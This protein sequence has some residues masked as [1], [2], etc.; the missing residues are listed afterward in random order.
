MA[1]KKT[2]NTVKA[3]PA[4]PASSQEREKALETAMAQIEKQYGK[5]AIMRLGENASMSVEHIRTGSLALD[6]AL[7]I[8]GIPRGRIVEIYGPES[9]GKTTVAL[10]CV[11]EAQKA[12]GNAAFIDVE[13]ALDPVY[14]AN[15]GVDIDNLL[16]SQPDSGEQALEIAEA[17]VRS[18]AIDIIVV[19][20]VAALTTKAEIEGE[21]GDAHVGQLARLM[22]QAMRKL[23]AALGKA[24]CAAIFINQLRDKIGVVYG[25]PETT[26]GGRAL[27]F[28]SSVRIDV[29]R[30]EYLKDGDRAIGSHTRAKIVKNK[31]APPFREAYFDI[32]YGEGISRTGELLDLGVDYELIKKGG[33]WFTINEERFQGR[34]N[35]KKYLAEHPEVADAL[36]AQIREAIQENREK[37]KQERQAHA[38][39]R[40]TAKPSEDEEQTPEEAPQRRS[41][42]VSIDADDFGDDDI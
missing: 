21:M 34:D 23:T 16:V 6:L 38:A 30:V 33:A 36:E 9:S 13:H 25:N 19:D 31:M 35:A 15:L 39:Q 42:A 22:S 3:A 32:M 41:A 5:G 8:G 11:A 37:A 14:A 29:R 20:S 27:K 17:L 28:Y 2:K 18:G 40:R 10:H 26:T 1:E 24:N 12:G 7:G 4:A